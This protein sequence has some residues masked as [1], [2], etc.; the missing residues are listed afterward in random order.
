[1]TTKQEAIFKFNTILAKQRKKLARDKQIIAAM[2]NNPSPSDM[3]SHSVRSS[4]RFVELVACVS[5]VAEY[6]DNVL[7][8]LN[9]D[10]SKATQE[11]YD[12]MRQRLHI[13]ERELR[14]LRRTAESRK[15]LLDQDAE[16]IKQ[17]RERVESLEKTPTYEKKTIIECTKRI[18]TEH[19]IT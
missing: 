16:V 2:C 15:A 1:M 4:N 5:E 9:D 12:F 7:P 3:V 14:D 17:L 13:Q 19:K 8:G 18:T 11:Q 10:L 6:I